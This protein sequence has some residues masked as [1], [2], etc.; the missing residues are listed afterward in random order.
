MLRTF[1][2]K[3]QCYFLS[4]PSC[5]YGAYHKGSTFGEG[6]KLHGH[7]KV[8][9]SKIG[10]FSYI[11][12]YSQISDC[13][14]GGFCSVGKEV[15]VGTG[16]HPTRWKSTSPFFYSA[17]AQLKTSLV[18]T[19][20]FF[21]TKSETI[22]GHDVWIGSRATILS[23][24]EVGHGAIV[25]AG[26]VVTRNVLPYEIVGGIP[27][28]SIGY[29]FTQNIIDDLLSEEWWDKPISALSENL[30]EFIGDYGKH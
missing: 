18:S 14:I 27:A 25:G 11:G 3:I 15:I 26:A 30:Q 28:K 22:I 23:G 19:E 2:R 1:I 9:R 5:I 21:S 29:R 7:A 24:V 6:V 4:S 12:D 8:M 16:D 20:K 10:R 17:G 13:S